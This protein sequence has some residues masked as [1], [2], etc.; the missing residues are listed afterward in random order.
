MSGIVGGWKSAS[1]GL[2]IAIAVACTAVVA[3]GAGVTVG[4]FV[5]PCTPSPER[6]STRPAETKRE[7]P[8]VRGAL[9][10]PAARPRPPPGVVEIVE[11]TDFGGP[12]RGLNALRG[13]VYFIP[14]G[15]GS[16]LDPAGLQPVALLYT[17]RL[18]IAPRSWRAGFPGVP[19]GRIEWFEID[20]QAEIWSARR[21]EYAF[22]L[23]SDDGTRLYV[24]DRLV[25]DNDG[26]HPPKSARGT[27]WLEPGKHR[28]RVGYFQGPRYE[29][30]LQ[31]FVTPPGGSKQIL[32]TSRV[33]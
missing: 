26:Q 25:V 12:H 23:L 4:L 5:G 1:V 27:A 20:Y 18:D 32:D 21:G 3:A 30:A 29:I 15:T 6:E 2:K 28:L 24:D 19:G 17:S 8:L 33:L 11:T 16:L 10:K 7:E 31:L 22:E 14:P 13:N 9:V